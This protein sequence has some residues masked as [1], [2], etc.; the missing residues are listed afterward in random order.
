MLARTVDSNTVEFFGAK[1]F[2]ED[3]SSKDSFRKRGIGHLENAV[4]TIFF[5]SSV[6]FLCFSD[7][8]LSIIPLTSVCGR[9]G[10]GKKFSLVLTIV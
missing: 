6:S 4:K 2:Q 3:A 8:H 7:S 10:I 5:C 9:R 1:L